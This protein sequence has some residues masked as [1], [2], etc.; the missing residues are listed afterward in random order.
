MYRASA[1]YDYT[2][3]SPVSGNMFLYNDTLYMAELLRT[4]SKERANSTDTATSKA[5]QKLDLSSDIALLETFG[6][7]KYSA[8]MESQKLILRDFLDGAQGF[9]NCTTSPFESECETAIASCVDRIRDLNAEWKGV[10]MRSALLQTLGSLLSTVTERILVDVEDLGDISE[11][12]SQKLVELCKK[13]S[14][15]ENLF[16]ND[17]SPGQALDVIEVVPET[18]LYCRNWFKFQYLSTIL[19]GS[20]ADIKYM[21]SE[22]ELSLEFGAEEVVDL[23]EALF[24]DSEHRRRA[25]GEIRRASRAF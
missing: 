16:L 9:S 25:I 19:E 24:S 12:Q 14:E 20:L 1:S 2:T 17:P 4:L 6:R 7:Q 18:G 11:A 10:L 23:I 13:V 5:G 3:A 8:E 15:L 22:G 21:W